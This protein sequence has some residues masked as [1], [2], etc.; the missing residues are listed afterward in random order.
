M[1][2]K[3]LLLTLLWLVHLSYW[4]ERDTLRGNTIENRGYL[5]V[6]IYVWTYACH[7]VLWPLHILVLALCSTP[8]QTSLNRILWFIN[9]YPCRPR[10]WIVYH[11]EFFCGATKTLKLVS[12]W[13]SVSGKLMRY[14]ISPTQQYLLENSLSTR[15]S[16]KVSLVLCSV[17]WKCCALQL[18]FS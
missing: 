16:T 7:F 3:T 10:N 1:K 2:L 14:V 9:R 13:V 11:S 5:L 8:S 4:R 15:L 12:I 17:V 6:Y 18:L